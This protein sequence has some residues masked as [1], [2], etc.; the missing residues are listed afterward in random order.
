MRKEEIIIEQVWCDLCGQKI[1]GEN[2]Y[3]VNVFPRTKGPAPIAYPSLMAS[4]GSKFKY[5]DV[6]PHCFREIL[7]VLTRL[8]NRKR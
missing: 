7:H 8:E 4:E 2:I 6:C 5:N 1:E 3:A